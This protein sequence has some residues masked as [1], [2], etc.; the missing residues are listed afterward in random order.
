M[1]R[2]FRNELQRRCKQAEA[3][4]DRTME[5]MTKLH[6]AYTL[7]DG[8]VEPQRITGETAGDDTIIPLYPDHAARIG[9][10]AEVQQAVQ[11]LL[12]QF[13]EEML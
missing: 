1:P 2:N 13:R 3:S 6:M 8:T 7:G 5:H 11:N 10:I 12:K 4:M 9:Q